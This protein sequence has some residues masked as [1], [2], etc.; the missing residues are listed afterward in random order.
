MQNKYI[1]WLDDLRNP[2][3]IKPG[4]QGVHTWKS[5]YFY[6]IIKNKR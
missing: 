1:L 3:D 6:I 2:D 5:M 4:T